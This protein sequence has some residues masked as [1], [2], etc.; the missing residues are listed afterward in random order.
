LSRAFIA[1]VGGNRRARLAAATGGDDYALLAAL[2]AEFEPTLSLSLPNRTIIA[3]I[4]T[5]TLG[6]ELSL[7]DAAGDVPLPEHLG[8]EHRRA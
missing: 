8:Y 5:L 7:F 3:P 6:N 4:G 1:E 2:P